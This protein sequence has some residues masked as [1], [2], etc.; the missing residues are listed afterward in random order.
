MLRPRFANCRGCIRVSLRS[1]WVT[2]T[3]RLY[4][5]QPFAEFEWTVGPVPIDD[6]NGKEAS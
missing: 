1:N 4:A 3:V 2:Q 5:G 6:N